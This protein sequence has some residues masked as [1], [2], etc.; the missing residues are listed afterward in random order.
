[1]G[2]DL[3]LTVSTG[4]ASSQYQW[5]K[6]GI[7]IGSISADS[8]YIINPVEFT[9]S[10][11]YTCEITN[12]VAT[13]LTLYSRPI[14]VSV[15]YPPMY[16]DSLALVA[17]YNS[18]D[19]ANWTDK[20]NWLTGDVSTWY[21]IT[22]TNDR[23]TGVDLWDNGLTGTLPPEIGNLSDLM[24]L[25]LST[26]QLTGSIPSS[27]GNLTKLNFLDFGANQFTG[28]IPSG[29][30]NLTDLVFLSFAHNNISGSIPAEIGILTN[31][32]YLDFNSNQFTGSIPGTIGNLVN[33]ELLLLEFNQLSGSIPPE[34]GNLSLLQGLYLHSNELS[35]SIP[36]E[37]GMLINITELNLADNLLT[38]AV[39]GWFTGLS[40][41][42]YLWLNS[43]SFV[44]FPDLSSHTSLKGLSIENN[45]L[46]FEDIEPNIGVPSESFIY[47]PQD[48]VGTAADTTLYWGTNSE[49]TISV[50]GANNLYQW[51]KDG[52]N[53]GSV[54]GQS[55]YTISPVLYSDSGT[56]TCEITNTVA[57]DLT[58]YSRPIHVTVDALHVSTNG[59][60]SNPGTAQEPFRTIMKAM[61]V[62]ETAALIKVAS[63]TYPEGLISQGPARIYGGYGEDFTE[64]GRNIFFNKTII[65]AIGTTMFT[66][67]HSCIINGLIFDGNGVA[68]KG[69]DLRANSI[70][71]FNIVFDINQGSGTAVD[72]TGAARVLN[73]TLYDNVMGI[74]I[75]NTGAVVKNN[76]IMNHSFG[77]NNLENEELAN[78]NCL[79]GNSFN[80]IGFYDIPGTGDIALDPELVDPGNGD[81]R[82][83]STSPCIDAGD[84]SSL[85]NDPDGS[86]NDIGAI[87]H[88]GVSSAKDIL[89]FSFIE[90]TNPATID[91]VNH[92][93]TIE[94][95][96][97]TDL[98][99]LAA[100]FS[101]SPG[102]SASVNSIDQVSGETTNDFSNP[103]TYTITAEDDSEQDWIVTVTLAPPLSSENDIL[104][105]TLAEQTS[106][107][108]IDNVNH[109]VTIFVPLSTDLTSL[110]ATFTLSSGAAAT[111]NSTGQVSGTTSNDFSGP[112]T[113]TVTA[114]D[115]T[116]QDWVV[117]VIKS[118]DIVVEDGIPYFQDFESND[119]GW[120]QGGTNSSWQYGTPSGDATINNAASGSNVWMTNLSGNHNAGEASF[121]YSPVFDLS[122]LSSPAIEMKV[123]WDSEG[124]YD[125][126]CMQYSDDTAKTWYTLLKSTDYLWYN[127]SD[128]VSILNIT[129][130]GKAWS[131]DGTFGEGSNGW[132]TVRNEI[133]GPVDFSYLR[134]RF[135]F[136]SNNSYE[137]DGFAFDDV[138]IYSDPAVG[139]SERQSDVND[140]KIYPNPGNG[141][142]TLTGNPGY[143]K[144]MVVEVMNING[145]IV[146]IREIQV[147]KY[148]HE[149]IDLSSFPKGIYFMRIKAG[150]HLDYQKIIIQ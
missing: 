104:S 137:N 147:T 63:G 100:T 128:V 118:D 85:Y 23:V 78:Y 66:D 139:I 114:E 105:F 62:A 33:L 26:N 15:E 42:E 1:I 8:T 82:L 135:L 149:Q 67:L 36:S 65:Q 7:N 133:T 43:N 14:N 125:G 18:T 123:W 111:V 32:T 56:Y 13:D 57:T 110:V 2:S 71:E 87:P 77:I 119:G 68:E 52:T 41:L 75:S 107:A 24:I 9:D 84:P 31:L 127:R 16:Q 131:G 44:D 96:Y 47:A 136:A 95:A 89:S 113:Y 69:L 50:G 22:V 19:G 112:V 145:Q 90:Q 150:D 144:D 59:D 45:K 106:S 27:I 101:L 5:K 134:F 73:N 37:I 132:V 34:I 11:T 108:N 143:T 10:G 98:T 120:T 130:S 60:D 25:K 12:T 109:T 141:I 91:N 39:P 115:G 64:A 70:A 48:S 80:Y 146:T 21:G 102:A 30:G 53:I 4:G 103:V 54:S 40:D 117:T 116:N 20:T 140:F 55:T 148:L 3:T 97:D 17:L 92:T 74:E 94:V 76:I 46:T 142:F 88:T 138:R 126:T 93:V 29:I 58:L 121:V 81:F 83:Q 86:R 61:S 51:K 129:G 124:T 72:I 122:G 35:G 49:L 6:N 28:S 99:S 79:Y 38:G